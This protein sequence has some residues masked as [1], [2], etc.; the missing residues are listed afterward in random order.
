MA[1]SSVTLAFD[2][3]VQEF[4][5]EQENIDDLRHDQAEIERKLEPS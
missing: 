3:E 1:C 2:D 4:L 5:K